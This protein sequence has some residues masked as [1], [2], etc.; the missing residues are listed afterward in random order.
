MHP[1]SISTNELTVDRN[2]AIDIFGSYGRSTDRLF[3]D[4]EF[5]RLFLDVYSYV[6]SEC[7]DYQN[8]FRVGLSLNKRYFGFPDGVEQVQEGWLTHECLVQLK[9][10]NSPVA[11]W[12]KKFRK[13]KISYKVSPIDLVRKL[14]AF[15]ANVSMTGRPHSLLY[16]SVIGRCPGDLLA[17]RAP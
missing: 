6:S 8:L 1:R 9:L 16:T 15:H 13:A 4:L 12:K 14:S 7:S 17:I 3:N 11:I 2:A 5:R 10:Y